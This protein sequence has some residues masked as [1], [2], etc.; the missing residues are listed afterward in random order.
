VRE[1]ILEPIV[2]YFRFQ[3][4]ISKISENSIVVDIGCGHTPHLLNRLERFIKNGVGIDP[5]IKSWQSGNVR[6]ISQLFS[7]KIPVKSGYADHVT[8][9]AVL[10]HAD[11][12][13]TLLLE[14]RRILKN[15]G[16]LIL[17]TP[18][19]LNKPLLEFLA[20]RL[21]LISPREIAEHKRYFWKKELVQKLKKAGF[22]KINHQYFEFF[23]NNFVVAS[24]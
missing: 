23:L 2:R 10:E 12:P 11:I 18:T 15:D 17:T 22:R 19:P 21:G 1:P 14:C 6:L 16:T 5:L 9:L 20:F 8:L 24:K 3:K 7:D 13:E 4:A